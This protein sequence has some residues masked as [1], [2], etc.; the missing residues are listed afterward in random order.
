[1]F[2]IYAALIA[3]S[4]INIVIV[5]ILNNLKSKNNYQKLKNENK[6]IFGG[7]IIALIGIVSPFI[8][9]S[10]KSIILNDKLGLGGLGDLGD[11]L[12]GSMSGLLAFASILFV[13]SAVVMQKEE[14]KLQ[15]TELK[16][17]R[18]EVQKMREEFEQSNKTMQIQQFETAFF[19]MINLHHTIVQNMKINDKGVSDRE[20]MKYLY[21][22]LMKVGREAYGKF[23]YDTIGNSRDSEE[24][25]IKK[26]VEKEKN[27]ILAKIKNSHYS[28]FRKKN[29]NYLEI[30]ENEKRNFYKEVNTIIEPRIFGQ[31]EWDE[32]KKEVYSYF[33]FKYEYLIGNY[34]RNIYHIVRFINDTLFITEDEK[35]HYISI[36]KAQLSSP[37]ILMIFYNMN[38]LKIGEKLKEQLKDTQFFDNHINNLELI[39]KEDYDK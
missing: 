26:L 23:R 22:K 29:N 17:Q 9:Y 34:F 20:V 39:W 31:D 4:I 5:I 6:W 25:F 15:R 21:E 27:E 11:F 37:E 14:L 28:N 38:Y 36:L 7:F 18:I 32:R 12:G 24:T 13:T 1:M 19:N 33:Y 3:F 30:L 2:E 8:L 16:L 10:T 35:K